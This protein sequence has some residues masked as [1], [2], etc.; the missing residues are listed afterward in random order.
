MQSWAFALVVF[1]LTSTRQTADGDASGPFAPLVP[2][3]LHWQPH[4][5][6]FDGCGR[7]AGNAIVRL[8]KTQ[9]Y[10]EVWPDIPLAGSLERPN[11]HSYT[12]SLFS[13][14]KECDERHRCNRHDLDILSGVL[15]ATQTASHWYLAEFL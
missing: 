11:S 9:R 4:G 7:A 8:F 5:I 6:S 3:W 10:W 13:S 12:L 15:L 1:V 14:A 2:F